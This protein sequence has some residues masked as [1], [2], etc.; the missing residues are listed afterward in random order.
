MSRV[1]PLMGNILGSMTLGL[2]NLFSQGLQIALL[3]WQRKAEF[4]ADRAG[5]LACQNVEA[6]TTLMMKLAG[7]PPKFYSNLK[8]EDFKKQ[9][10]EFEEFDEDNLD[11]IAKAI[12]VMFEEHPWTVMRGHELY[13]WIDSGEYDNV[14][15]RNTLTN[16]SNKKRSNN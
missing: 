11:K 16:D 8:V 2:G 7:A 4:T 12:S 6:A 15:E 1:I 13:K 14:L 9:A 3:N 5:L 10:K